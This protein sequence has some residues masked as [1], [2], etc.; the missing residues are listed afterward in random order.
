MSCPEHVAVYPD[1]VTGGIMTVWDGQHRTNTLPD[2]VAA[3]KLRHLELHRLGGDGVGAVLRFMTSLQSLECYDTPVEP[4]DLPVQLQ[5][6]VPGSP[7]ARLN[8]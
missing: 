2:L 8:R 5:T 7:S 1:P 3:T 6:L 4:E